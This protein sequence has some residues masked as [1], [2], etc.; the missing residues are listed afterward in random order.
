M[1]NVSIVGR[2]TKEIEL[3]YSTGNNTFC[4]FTI[5]VNRNFK[6]AN[7]EYGT[8]FINC[9]AFGNTANFMDRYLNKG[10]LISIT[11]RIQTRN[12]TNKQNQKIFI[13]EINASEVRSLEKINKNNDQQF[14]NQVTPQQFN[15]QVTPQQFMGN[16]TSS[17]TSDDLPF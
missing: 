11:G 1:N 12:Y 5:A 17:I 15:N 3:K 14:N 8:D 6:D 9:V 13:T 16:Q 7:G 4:N 2:L 10:T